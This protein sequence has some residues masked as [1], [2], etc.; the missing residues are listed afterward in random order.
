VVEDTMDKPG[1]FRR[2]VEMFAPSPPIH[3]GGL[4][5]PTLT[6]VEVQKASTAV[7]RMGVE[8]S[9]PLVPAGVS[10]TLAGIVNGS[11]GTFP[12]ANPRIEIRDVVMD[13]FV[14]APLET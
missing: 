5:F 8:E 6:I 14:E 4:E 13:I 12:H 9:N 2:C 11:I 7:E 3:I 10:G 1:E